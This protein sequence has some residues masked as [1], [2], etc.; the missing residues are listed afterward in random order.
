MLAE[1]IYLLNEHNKI[2][3]FSLAQRLHATASPVVISGRCR[4]I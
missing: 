3:F 1:I 4:S 2:N